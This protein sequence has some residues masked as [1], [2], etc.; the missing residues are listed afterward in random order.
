MNK[1][2]LPYFIIR[3]VWLV[4]ALVM[5]IIALNV[6]I[7]PGDDA[8]WFLACFLC[9]IPI[10]LPIMRFILRAFGV[11][12]AAGSNEYEIDFSNGRIYNRG[13][14][15]ALIVGI[16]AIIAVIVFGIVILPIYWLYAVYVTVRLG[17][18]V[19]RRQ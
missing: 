2:G 12:W 8:K 13:W 6:V 10:A 18:D 3:C 9:L 16:I 4:F 17:I 14:K 7:N 11:G 1:Q 15:V 5:W 19:F